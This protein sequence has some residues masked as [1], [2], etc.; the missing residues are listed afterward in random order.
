MMIEIHVPDLADVEEQADYVEVVAA[1]LR[2]G[3]FGG[4]VDAETNW[5][6]RD[7]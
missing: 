1:Q 3:Y 2:D 6:T 5:K 4:H 7:D